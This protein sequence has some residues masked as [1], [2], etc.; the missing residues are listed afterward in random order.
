MEHRTKGMMAETIKRLETTI[1][2]LKS[3]IK[4]LS[5]NEALSNCLQSCEEWRASNQQ[6]MRT[7]RELRN[8]NR[9]LEIENKA[10]KDLFERFGLPKHVKDAYIEHHGHTASAI[11]IAT[12]WIC[13]PQQEFK[14]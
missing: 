5:N 1:V 13:N 7:G 4:R 9:Q 14:L 3:E 12:W 2:G 8:K 10:Y 11:V 6:L